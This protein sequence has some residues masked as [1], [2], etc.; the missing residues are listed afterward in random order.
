MRGSRKSLIIS[1]SRRTDIPA[2][3]AKWF[4]NRIRAGYCVVPNPC[5][6]Q[7]HS[8]ISLRPEDV[9]VIVFWTR[10]P[11]PLM[12]YLKELDERGYRYYFQYTLMDN[13]PEL[14][15]KMPELKVRIETFRELSEKIG[16][17][18]VVWRY[19]PIV[20]SS[21]TPPEFHLERHQ[22]IAE[23]LAGYTKRNV[24]SIVDTHYRKI[25]PRLQIASKAGMSFKRWRDRYGE[26]VRQLAETAQKHGMEIQ[27]CAEDI[28]LRPY[29]VQ[30]GK[31]IDDDL[32]YRAFGIKVS[33]KK[34]KGQREACG[35]VESRDIGAY[36]TCLFG[37]IYCYATSSFDKARENHQLHN[38]QSPSLIGWYDIPETPETPEEK[39]AEQKTL[40]F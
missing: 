26:F 5:N 8:R 24:I 16:S 7:R 35:C 29:G 10:H 38:P 9:S 40:D 3:Y 12:P 34:D 1:A 4:I 6:P 2:F 25:K 21:K 30:P 27:S 11:R 17:L 37:C 39:K 15:P 13:P 22:M 32:I 18:R 19:D 33:S 31:C 36:D 23:Q 20:I 28:D 14:D